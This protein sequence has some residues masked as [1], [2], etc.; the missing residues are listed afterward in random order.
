M[1]YNTLEKAIET[2]L[3]RAWTDSN[4]VMRYHVCP[5]P[6]KRFGV[7]ASGNEHEP[8]A[9][10][11]ARAEGSEASKRID[12]VAKLRQTAKETAQDLRERMGREELQRD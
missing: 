1:K 9:I 4:D 12:D 11:T 10:Y 3:R 7:V 5:T 6:G 8:G 2:A